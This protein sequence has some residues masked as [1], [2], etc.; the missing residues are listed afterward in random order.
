MNDLSVLLMKLLIGCCSG[1]TIV[2]H[3]MYADDTALLAPLAKGLQRLLDVSYN[4][5]CDNDIL[6]NRV[7]SQIMFLSQ[8]KP[9]LR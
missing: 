2:N 3:P 9:V 5:G 7:K 8:G 4:Y 6:F 1:D